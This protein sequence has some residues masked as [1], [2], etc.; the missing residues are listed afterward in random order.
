MFPFISCDDKCHNRYK[1]LEVMTLF[2]F[3]N[4]KMN[5]NLQNSFEGG[6]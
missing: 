4:Q 3:L 5:K 2:A 6:L 1:I